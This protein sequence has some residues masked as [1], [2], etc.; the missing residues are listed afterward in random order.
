MLQILSL[1]SMLSY[2][3]FCHEYWRAFP[4]LDG[5]PEV[6]ESLQDFRKKSDALFNHIQLIYYRTDDH[7]GVINLKHVIYT[8]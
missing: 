3:F 2:G 1:M 5:L 6:F 8:S 4:I 7:N